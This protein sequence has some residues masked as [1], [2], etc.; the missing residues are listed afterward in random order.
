MFELLVSLGIQKIPITY[1]N[2]ASGTTLTP[3]DAR[4]ILLIKMEYLK[5]LGVLPDYLGTKI[6]FI[7]KYTSL[8][9]EEF[10]CYL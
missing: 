10:E 2:L 9:G 6:S 3:T 7:V 8:Y 5:K 4:R 1:D